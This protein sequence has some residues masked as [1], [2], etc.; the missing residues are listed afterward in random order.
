MCQ[1]CLP[2]ATRLA[3]NVVSHVNFDISG[4]HTL[5]FPS[6]SAQSAEILHE[7]HVF[8]GGPIVTM[9]HGDPHRVESL[10]TFDD[11]ILAAGSASDVQEQVDRLVRKGLSMGMAHLDEA[12]YRSPDFTRGHGGPEGPFGRTLAHSIKFLLAS[13][14]SYRKAGCISM[15]VLS[16]K[17]NYFAFA[18]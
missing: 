6:V 1:S 13:S 17:P 18:I 15:P 12:A 10:A 3:R 2:A 7:I 16:A 4:L 9:K 5:E 14:E 8:T 11:I